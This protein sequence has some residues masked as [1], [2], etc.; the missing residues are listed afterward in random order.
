MVYEEIIIKSGDTLSQI[1]L[2]YG[3]F[4]SDYPKIWEHPAN[5]AIRMERRN[6]TNIYAGDK[7][8]I[9][10]PWIIVNK[11]F[12]A[13][14]RNFH[15]VRNGGKGKYLR[16]TQTVFGDNAPR[17]GTLSF[18]F[19]VDSD[20]DDDPYYYTSV[21]LATDDTLRKNFSDAPNR[22]YITGRTCTWRAV[23]SICSVYEKRVSV[24][25]SIVWG[26]DFHTN[27]T[28][29]QVQPR[30]ASP[31]EIEGHIHLLKIG[32]GQ[33]MTYKAG[34]WTFRKAPVL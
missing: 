3:Y 15:A 30:K 34:G 5:N 22:T 10:L 13:N 4:A 32:S 24:F 1:V 16:W 18:P 17:R 7:I 14:T 31:T 23:L 8:I 6:P 27:G 25:E 26:I 21:E 12:T 11:G 19:T 28:F 33:T 2:D 9:P 29:T 20:D